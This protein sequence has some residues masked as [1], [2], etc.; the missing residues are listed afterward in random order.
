VPV[1]DIEHMHSPPQHEVNS[2][3]VGEGGLLGAPAAVLNAV[4]DA[5]GPLGVAINETHL[6]P[7]R[8]R[9]L[10]DQANGA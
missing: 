2:R 9:E 5:L 1:I 6:P 4:A 8:I 3:G 10:I 7:Q